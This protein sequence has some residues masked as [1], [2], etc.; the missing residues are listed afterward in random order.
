MTT[1]P[2][3][4]AN[5]ILVIDDD[6]LVCESVKMI[7][8]PV[9][10]EVTM[11]GSGRQALALLETG[12]FDLILVDYSMP[13]MRGDELAVIVKQLAPGLPVIIMTAYA[14]M[15]ECSLTPVVGVAHV[16]EKPFLA[17]ELR[18]TIARFLPGRKS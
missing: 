16:L 11:A 5:R 17:G 13:R 2:D 15:L 14:E 3:S 18:E 4:A 7:L 1:T 12:K 6:P 9:G 8:D 10:Y